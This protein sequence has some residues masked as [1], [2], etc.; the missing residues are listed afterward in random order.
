MTWKQ[1]QRTLEARAR[2]AMRGRVIKPG[3]ALNRAA[4]RRGRHESNQLRSLLRRIYGYRGEKPVT[5]AY[6][7]FHDGRITRSELDF[8]KRLT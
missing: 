8:L 4:R 2:L 7:A 1:L 6:R 5:R 3:T